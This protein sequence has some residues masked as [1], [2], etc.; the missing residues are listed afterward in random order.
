MTPSKRIT[1][2]AAILALA[3]PVAPASVAYD[4]ICVSNRGAFNAYFQFKVKDRARNEVRDYAP[5][6][7]NYAVNVDFSD[8]ND[9][10]EFN[11]GITTINHHSNSWYSFPTGKTHCI[12]KEYIREHTSINPGDAFSISAGAVLGEVEYC[13]LAN[14]ERRW[15]DD[16]NAWHR[17]F[18]WPENGGRLDLT[19]WGTTGVLHCDI[20]G[21]EYMWE[22]CAQGR[23][24]FRK[25]ACYPWRPRINPNSA[26]DLTADE[27]K[28]IAYLAS[29]A[30]RGANLDARR[31][32][33]YP[34]HV[35]V[36]LNR[37]DHT[38][39]LLGQGQ[40]LNGGDALDSNRN[41][42]R[43]N[44]QNGEGE[45]P[46]FY[47][48]KLNRLAH[49]RALL[50][51]GADVNLVNNQGE[52]PLLAAIRANHAA[53]GLT[54]MVNLLT[55]NGANVNARS[56]GGA[57]I[58]HTA[59]NYG[60]T[61]VLRALIAAGSETYVKDGADKTAL[62]YV[63]AG[64]EGHPA[65]LETDAG[66]EA[67]ETKY[68][69]I[70]AILFKDNLSKAV[71]RRDLA[72]LRE[73]ATYTVRDWADPNITLEGGDVAA[74]LRAYE[75]DWPE[76]VAVLAPMTGINLEAPRASDNRRPLHISVAEDHA[77]A[78]AALLDNGAEIDARAG[79]GGDTA[80]MI[81]ARD[82]RISIGET[83]IARGADKTLKDSEG[84]TALDLA[85]LGGRAE[86]ELALMNAGA[87]RA[88]T[89]ED[90]RAV[91][92]RDDS[93]RTVLHRVAAE[94]NAERIAAVLAQQPQVNARDDDGNTPLI[95]AVRENENDARAV[96]AA[97][98]LLGA[99]ATPHRADENGRSPLYHAATRGQLE[100]LRALLDYGVSPVRDS[101]GAPPL[102]Y[103]VW[104]DDGDVVALLTS[105]GAD[106]NS[107]V[108]AGRHSTDPRALVLREFPMLI[109]A[110]HLGNAAATREL[111]RAGAAVR[112]VHGR[113][114][115]VNG[116]SAMEYALHGHGTTYA[117]RWLEDSRLNDSER[118]ARR[119]ADAV[120]AELSLA[121]MDWHTEELRKAA[122]LPDAYPKL[123]GLRSAGSTGGLRPNQTASV[124]HIIDF[125]LRNP[126]DRAGLTAI[127]HRGPYRP[128]VAGVGGE[129]GS[130]DPNRLNSRG[131]SAMH[132]VAQHS[133][134]ALRVFFKPY[135]HNDWEADPNLKDSAGKTILHWT[136]ESPAAPAP[137]NG[138]IAQIVR[139]L[140]DQGADLTIADADGNLPIHT[141][142]RNGHI[143]AFS[144]LLNGGADPAARNRAGQTPLNLAFNDGIRNLLQ[145]ALTN[146][147][148]EDGRTALHRAVLQNPA[149]VPAV[150]ARGTDANIR[151]N[152]GNTALML[153]IVSGRMSE[154]TAEALLDAGTNLAYGNNDGNLPLHAAA[155]R[156]V[157]G[158]AKALADAGARAD[159]ERLDGWLPLHL[160]AAQGKTTDN[161]DSLA[162]DNSDYAE[163]IS[164]IL[165]APGVNI[166]SRA[167]NDRA[168][169]HLAVAHNTPAAVTALANG[170]AYLFSYDRNGGYSPRDMALRMKRYNILDALIKAGSGFPDALGWVRRAI[171][172]GEPG[173]LRTLYNNGTRV[174]PSLYRTSHSEEFVQIW[175]DFGVLT[176]VFRETTNAPAGTHMHHAARNGDL[177]RVNGLLN[178]GANPSLND[179]EGRKPL[180]FAVIGGHDEVALALINAGAEGVDEL[181]TQTLLR[182]L[183]AFDEEN[184]TALLEAGADLNVSEL[185]PNRENALHIAARRNFERL[186]RQFA[187]EA[188]SDDFQ[189]ENGGGKTPLALARATNNAELILFLENSTLDP[190][191]TM[192]SDGDTR[193]HIAARAGD[194]D[195]VKRWLDAGANPDSE[196]NNGF[197]PLH[198]A[199]DT[200][201]DPKVDA[202][203]ALLE[204]GA[205]PNAPSGLNGGAGA[206]Q[207]TPLHYAA[208]FSHFELVRLYLDAGADPLLGRYGGMN[209]L[210][211]ARWGADNRGQEEG[212]QTIAI[213][214]EATAEAQ[215]FADATAAAMEEI[216]S[217]IDSNNA[218]RV[219]DALRDHETDAAGWLAL[220]ERAHG[221]TRGTKANASLAVADAIAALGQTEAAAALDYQNRRGKA[222]AHLAAIRGQVER[223]RAF[224]EAGAN[225]NLQ[226]RDG[227]TPLST[228]I[229]R[230]R[231]DSANA[232]LSLGAE[233]DSGE[234]A[235]RALPGDALRALLLGEDESSP[236][237]F[238]DLTAF[239]IEVLGDPNTAQPDG[240]Q[241]LQAALED[242]D[243]DRAYVLLALG[244]EVNARGSD[245]RTPLMAAI[246][247]GLSPE[248][249]ERLMDRGADPALEDA[250]GKNATTLAEE[251]GLDSALQILR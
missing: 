30:R 109:H 152:D 165:R 39:V 38:R 174:E 213:L 71:E 161:A 35:A 251:K 239:I 34:L 245:G 64:A 147:Q 57:L 28:S 111:L 199:S 173:L 178:H 137:A 156:G 132:R 249:L 182:A 6:L 40:Y 102:W 106:P 229:E 15:D 55:E 12:S 105:R 124:D 96:A 74:L 93:G 208:K 94:G 136:L 135:E 185:G 151:D 67:A 121:G 172:D 86:L 250:E 99:G 141:A 45:S 133:L 95:L 177:P 19:V 123:A 233:Q 181:S 220:M 241:P 82:N 88:A 104:K 24:G 60:L 217:A 168:P 36:R 246:E 100:V 69:E 80:L 223:L 140:L 117:S 91:N 11:H 154:E 247:A 42:A 240:R 83:L 200:L 31:N 214:E 215:G 43:L 76:A 143:D 51:N 205:D 27:T 159:Q 146:G 230:K 63:F 32:N 184:F 139:F 108:H 236:P 226:D 87:P 66:R 122:N 192:N 175:R 112:D 41:R 167:P 191:A 222:V 8:K 126:N 20:R 125:V 202:A 204:G 59:A 22:G 142:A 84:K 54:D 158:A 81:A 26:Y 49:I 4:E 201:H 195:E 56:T 62:D 115:T 33:E 46:L 128:A 160:A 61:D 10:A 183:N 3:L 110:A 224:A 244:A 23:E 85:T 248:M 89:T 212:E 189:A 134:A 163:T 162:N 72:R 209:A 113:V 228:A 78:L 107:S 186:A 1:A 170:G 150:I 120:M 190:D 188:E 238:P 52:I 7:R 166:D 92:Q 131:H 18:T 90:D 176:A 198:V 219:A 234:S 129:I 148:D 114:P 243:E 235:L 164:A 119:R 193:L 194:A 97:R 225:I 68:A 16:G 58:L 25:S 153:G 187:E 47:A 206:L 44:W 211:M 227:K 9:R 98:L 207:E 197:R 144:A 37:L 73:L 65:G 149:E 179:R 29:V 13:H 21:G 155:E 48:A 50:L 17:V 232:L 237:R 101:N 221:G 169:I 231:G 53:S 103:G 75:L 157:P 70:G 79:E 196:N 77:E 116:K 216:H 118:A 5:Q 180:H 14:N 145:A 2:L 138:T 210:D 242:G 171:H 130:P 203:R 127:L 218:N